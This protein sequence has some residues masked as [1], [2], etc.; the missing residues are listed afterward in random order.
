MKNV[1]ALFS[2]LVLV[3][4]LAQPA[5][6]NDKPTNLSTSPL[7][8]TVD[9]SIGSISVWSG[10][11]PNLVSM[12]RRSSSGPC[13]QI[14]FEITA[15]LPYSQLDQ[16]NGPQVDFELWSSRGKK[17][18]SHWIFRSSWNPVSSVNLV[19]IFVCDGEES[20]GSHTLIIKTKYQVST[21]GLLTRYFETTISQ[22][23]TIVEPV[24]APGEPVIANAN[25]FG[26]SAINFSV[27]RAVTGGPTNT[28]E[29]ALSPL[30]R[31]GLDLTRY[32]NYETPVVFRT[33]T[34]FTNFRVTLQEVAQLYATQGW[35]PRMPFMV[36]VRSVG[37]EGAVSDWSNGYYFT[38]SSLPTPA[39]QSCDATETTF[40]TWTK[41]I[42]DR[43]LK[44]YARE[45][46]GVG[47]VSFRINGKEIAWVRATNN[48]D[49]KLNLAGD[50]MVRTAQ[51][52][53]GRNVLEIHVGSCRSTRTIYSR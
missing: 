29:V 53:S 32:A 21:T 23:L 6:G 30:R 13:G 18:G 14:E 51:L 49:S 3:A 36:R 45:I 40:R 46:V 19:D 28:L 7:V 8:G 50:G 37:S 47:K 48:L 1:L 12:P 38:P 42:S 5:N 10:D 16:L 2:S 33:V 31:S 43:E 20:Y 34:G 11:V 22:P 24:Q 17:I 35:N 39:V 44:F 52:S 9:T 25:W 27:E 26:D 15:L 41:R 4:T